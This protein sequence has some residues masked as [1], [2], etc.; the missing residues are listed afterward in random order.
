[1]RYVFVMVGLKS[2]NIPVNEEKQILHEFITENYGGHTPAEIKLAFKLAITRKLDLKPAD[3]VCYENFSIAYFSRVMEAYRD[4]SR[5]QIKQL[6]APEEKPRQFNR[7]ERL[8]LDF[9]YAFILLSQIN[10]PPCKV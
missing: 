6:P 4:W 5:E 7:Q 8:Q 3:V 10:K 1:M 9:D 2:Q